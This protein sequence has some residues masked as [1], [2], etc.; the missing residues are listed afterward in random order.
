MAFSKTTVV[1]SL[2]F[3]DGRLDLVALQFADFE[4]YCY[5]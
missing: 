3:S 2:N 4:S 5:S 1:V